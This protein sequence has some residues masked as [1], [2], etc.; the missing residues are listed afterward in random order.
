MRTPPPPPR[1]ILKLLDTHYPSNSC[2]SAMRPTVGFY[3]FLLSIAWIYSSLAEVARLDVAIHRFE[4]NLNYRFRSSC[5]SKSSHC[6]AQCDLTFRLCIRPFDVD[7][8]SDE[9]SRTGPCEF[10]SLNLTRKD[11][12]YKYGKD[13]GVRKTLKIVDRWPVSS[14]SL[15]D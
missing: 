1:Y 12:D 13:N 9:R 3:S 4:N 7:L 8:S 14:F 6:D 11:L 5:C 10:G 2:S 15:F